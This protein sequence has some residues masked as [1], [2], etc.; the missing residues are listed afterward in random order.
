MAKQDKYQLPFNTIITVVALKGSLCYI[1]NMTFGHAL[2]KAEANRG[3][4]WHYKNYKLGY[5]AM[6]E[7]HK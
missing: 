1:E 6:K 7:K 4:G 3:N 5:C 2:E